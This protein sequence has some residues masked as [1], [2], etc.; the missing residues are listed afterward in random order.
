M[1]CAL[2]DNINIDKTAIVTVLE[3]VLERIERTM[4]TQPLK[5]PEA[6]ERHDET[7]CETSLVKVPKRI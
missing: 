3:N 7:V 5:G 1:E 2:L 6:L 4:Q